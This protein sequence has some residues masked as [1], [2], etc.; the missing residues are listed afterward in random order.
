MDE[1][2]NNEKP[3]QTKGTEVTN[4]NDNTQIPPK[5]AHCHPNSTIFKQETDTCKC[6]NQCSRIKKLLSALQYYELLNISKNVSNADVFMDFVESVYHK[7]D[8]L[9][10]YTHLIDEHGNAINEI[11][12][13]K[14]KCNGLETCSC[15]I[16]HQKHDKI[17]GILD[18]QF[19]FY[20]R[21]MDSLHF[22]L[23][24][25]FESGL[26]TVNTVNTDHEMKNDNCNDKK[27]DFENEYFDKWFYRLNK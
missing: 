8:I 11:D 20:K 5:K 14:I 16:R 12:T 21:I 18:L 24:H 19:N 6:A 9:N 15:T 13:S 1:S 22:Y 4:N 10:D 23:C 27:I 25:I 2:P 7:K 3:N 26:R 17:D